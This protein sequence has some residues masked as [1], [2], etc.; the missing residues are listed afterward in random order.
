MNAYWR[1][2]VIAMVLA[3]LGAGPAQAQVIRDMTL[4]RIRETEQTKASRFAY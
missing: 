3:V 1:T 4:E 2:L